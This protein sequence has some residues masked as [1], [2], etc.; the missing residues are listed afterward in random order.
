MLA[1]HKTSALQ[2]AT[3]RAGQPVVLGDIGGTT[4]RFAFLTE[5]KLGIVDHISV[6][7]YSSFADALEAFVHRHAAQTRSCRAL[8]AVAGPVEMGRCALV[9]NQ[10]V[11]DVS[12]LSARFGFAKVDL[13]N[14][15]EAT[16]W[17]LPQLLPSD[18]RA[19][20]GGQSVSDAPM[21][22]IGPGTGLGVAGFIPDPGNPRVVATEGGHSTLPSSSPRED[23]VIQLLRQQFGHVSSERALS[24]GGL[25][26][27]YRALSKLDRAL[28]PHRTAADITRAALGGT[29]Q[30]SRAAL[31]MF[32]GMLGTVAGNIALCFGA[33]GGIYLAG[34]IVPQITDFLAWSSF[35]E[36]FEA[37]GRLS[38]YLASIP[39]SVIM[40][41]DVAFLGLQTLAQN[42]SCRSA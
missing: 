2:R 30:I 8:F 16:A 24:G 28:V 20:G 12:E 1:D 29:C 9:N 42:D 26:N 25:E 35:R 40:H 22:V 34:G 19:V 4:A 13:I 7:D 39:T 10:W 38:G 17:S 15:F 36:R 5:R 33:R 31:D 6:V 3:V 41:P 27:L 11:V 14:D 32:C 23:A 21:A 18:L 37:K